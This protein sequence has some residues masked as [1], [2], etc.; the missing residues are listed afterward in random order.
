[1]RYGRDY[2]RNEHK[3]NIGTFIVLFWNVCFLYILGNKG[4]EMSIARCDEC[5]AHFDTDYEESFCDL[6]DTWLCVYCYE[7]LFEEKENK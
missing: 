5:E 3:Y 2:T 7:K 6:Y 1:M 4:E